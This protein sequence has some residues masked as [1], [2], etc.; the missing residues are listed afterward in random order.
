MLH[1]VCNVILLFCEI[2]IDQIQIELG[3]VYLLRHLVT[4]AVKV[5]ASFIDRAKVTS[6]S[7]RE[8]A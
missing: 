5:V 7:S 1:P 3:W 4:N 8:K 2:H 6:L